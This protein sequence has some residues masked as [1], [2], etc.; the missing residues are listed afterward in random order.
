MSREMSL[1]TQMWELFAST[2]KAMGFAFDGNLRRRTGTHGRML[3]G[4]YEEVRQ[5]LVPKGNAISE[6]DLKRW[7]AKFDRLQRTHGQP[8]RALRRE[9]DRFVKDFKAGGPDLD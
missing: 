6:T 9:R 1:E 3:S 8:M 5:Q 2:W 7:T 4:F